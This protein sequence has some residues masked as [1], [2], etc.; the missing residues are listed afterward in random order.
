MNCWVDSDCGEPEFAVGVEA[1]ILYGEWNF[2][3]SIGEVL[4]QVLVKVG[5]VGSCDSGRCGWVS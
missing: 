5:G 2:G 1:S 3:D 4:C